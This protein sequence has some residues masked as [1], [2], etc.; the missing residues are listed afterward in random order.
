MVLRKLATAIRNYNWFT[1]FIELLIV[2]FGVYIGIYLGDVQ[3]DAQHQAETLQALNALKEEF[4]S[5]LA[6]VD[7]VIEFQAERIDIYQEVSELLSQNNL[8]GASISALF[9]VVSGGRNDTYFPNRAA[10]EA[11]RTGGYMAALP[12]E[13]LRL[14]ITRLIERNYVRQELNADYYDQQ[15][16]YFGR[17]MMALHWDF[18]EN[19]LLTEDG[20][21]ILR[22]GM[23]EIEGRA[24]FYRGFLSNTVRPEMEKTVLMIDSFQ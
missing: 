17:E 23:R 1:V 2:I 12:V 19:Q 15:I 16:L 9:Q 18:G 3:Q 7:E 14:Q 10:Y 22:N 20:G 11:M 24:V 13:A 6:R 4:E 5:D 8:D 21:T